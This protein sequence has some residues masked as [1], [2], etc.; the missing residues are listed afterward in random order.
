MNLF[1]IAFGSNFCGYQQPGVYTNVIR[2][3]DWIEPI[4]WPI[5]ISKVK[6]PEPKNHG[7]SL[8]FYIPKS[9][10]PK[11]DAIPTTSK[12]PAPDHPILVMT[13]DASQEKTTTTTTTTSTTTI[14]TTAKPLNTLQTSS[15]MDAF[16]SPLIVI[17]LQRSVYIFRFL[18]LAT[19]MPTTSTVAPSVSTTSFP[20]T[21]NPNP[22]SYKTI[23][24][25]NASPFK[26]TPFLIPNN[27]PFYIPDI[28]SGFM[29]LTEL[30]ENSGLKKYYVEKYSKNKDIKD[31]VQNA[32]NTGW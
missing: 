20:I 24:P 14:H 11:P 1:Y 18:S 26:S 30:L 7:D 32:L 10:N 16:R 9:K 13:G 6:I 25:F 28:T 19:P 17:Y 23:K 21:S 31:I 22:T 15:G 29:N 27:D 4:V 5:E 8:S 12:R 2:Y 3:L